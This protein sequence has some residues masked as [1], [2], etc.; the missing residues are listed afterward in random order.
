MTGIYACLSYCWG[1]SKPSVTTVSNQAQRLAGFAI[2]E[3]PATLRDAVYFTRRLGLRY[4]WVD[5][6]CIFQGD[7]D[8]WERESANMSRIYGHSYITLCASHTGDIN[9]G[10]FTKLDQAKDGP[11]LLKGDHNGQECQ[12]YARKELSHHQF[13]ALDDAVPGVWAED[14]YP[15]MERAWAL[16]EHLLSRRVIQ[17]ATHELMWD[18]WEH[19]ACGCGGLDNL[20][21]SRGG[22]LRPS[23]SQETSSFLA[24]TW[25]DIL[26]AYTCRIASDP[27]D[28]L[29]A[30]SGLAHAVQDR[31][32]SRY[33]AG[34]WEHNLVNELLWYKPPSALK[35][36]PKRVNKYRAPSWSWASVDGHIFHCNGKLLTRETQIAE[37]YEVQTVL[38]GLDPMGAV[39]DGYIKMKTPMTEICYE[40]VGPSSNHP[41][42]MCKKNDLSAAFRPLWAFEHP[43]SHHVPSGTI[44]PCIILGRSDSTMAIVLQQLGSADRTFERIASFFF[45]DSEES[46]SWFADARMTELTI[47]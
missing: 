25:N 13:T 46:K 42:Y 18:C 45:D 24:E 1:K 14:R 34:I 29:P 22:L 39:S 5:A 19:S 35:R 12:I 27:G 17:F 7:R 36:Y 31:M 38:S 44:F 16:Q 26:H 37:I 28:K 2:E 3:L 10:L 11:F 8:D 32:G 30:M 20:T 21:S 47:V 41:T 6:L 33:L 43:G 23:S 40:Y 4:L 9:D 15:L